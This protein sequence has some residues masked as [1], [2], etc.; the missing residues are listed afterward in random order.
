MIGSQRLRADHSVG[1]VI[2]SLVF[3]E[4][5]IDGEDVGRTVTFSFDAKTDDLSGSSEALAFIKTLDPAAGFVTTNSVVLDTT[6]LPDDWRRYD[7]HLELDVGLVG[8]LLQVGFSTTATNFEPSS[9]FY[10]NV[11]RRIEVSDAPVVCEVPFGVC[12]DFESLDILSGTALADDGW[13]YFANVFAP[14]GTYLYGYG[15]SGAP[16]GGTGFSAIVSGEGGSEQPFG[17]G[18][19]FQG[20]LSEVYV[21]MRRCPQPIISLVHGPA[22]GGGS[23][24]FS[25]TRR[26]AFG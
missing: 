15:P 17:S 20:Y 4:R 2:E 26:W 14:D 25:P 1:N 11:E 16:N 13:I 5:S 22:C 9:N 8:Q 3:Q 24:R 21:R 18:D 12:R 10:D 6:A 19:G 7:I 23:T